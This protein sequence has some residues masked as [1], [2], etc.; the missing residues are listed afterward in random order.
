M[1]NKE[2][3]IDLTPFRGILSTSFTGRV[4]GQD[5]RKKLKLEKIERNYLSIQIKIPQGTTSFNPSFFL[6]LF[7]KSIKSL[8]SIDE[9]NKKYQFTFDENEDEI[10][11]KIIRQNITEALNYAKSSLI[12]SEKGFRF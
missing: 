6:G 12:D 11:K 9:F 2:T 4:Q 10:L 5:V 8:G 3:I 1:K 7:Y